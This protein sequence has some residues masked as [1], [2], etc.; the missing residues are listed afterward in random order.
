MLRG[1]FKP[2]EGST[3]LCTRNFAFPGVRAQQAA[4]FGRYACHFSG[5]INNLMAPVGIDCCS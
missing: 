1:V 4:T 2:A 5:F 3:L